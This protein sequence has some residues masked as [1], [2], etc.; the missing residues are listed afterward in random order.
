MLLWTVHLWTDDK[1]TLPLCSVPFLNWQ[2]SF[3]FSSSL[4]VKYTTL[5]WWVKCD[6]SCISNS[7]KDVKGYFTQ[8][9]I[10]TSMSE[11]YMVDLKWSFLFF[12]SFCFC[13]LV[14]LLDSANV[15]SKSYR[16]RYFSLTGKPVVYKSGSCSW[17]GQ[18]STW[19]TLIKLEQVWW[20]MSMLVLIQ[21]QDVAKMF[22]NCNIGSVLFFFHKEMSW[23]IFTSVYLTCESM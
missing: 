10:P 9:Q 22:H 8:G 21:L 20:S 11:C 23:S 2:Y 6:T 7:F 1:I 12:F 15:F 16:V 3:L 17:C 4:L 13:C 19:L 14:L 5:L 18:L